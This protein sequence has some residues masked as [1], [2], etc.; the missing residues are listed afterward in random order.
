MKTVRLGKSSL[1]SS[2]LAY[3]CWRV[4]GAPDPEHVTPERRSAGHA[5]ILAA[6]EA[7]YT[8]FDHADV[9]CRGEAETIFGEVLREVSGMRERVLIATKCG[10]RPAGDPD[11]HAPYRYDFSAS[12]IVASCE[13]SLR[14]L[15]VEVIDLYLLHRPDFLCDPAEV[16][17][18]F[19]KLKESGKVREFGV[20]NFRPSQWLMLQ[21]AC[22]LP[23]VV[24]QIQASLLH[25][26]PFLDGTLDQ[27][28]ANQVV[29]M[30]W[31]P[32]AA[33]I[34]GGRI[35]VAMNDPQHARKAKLDDVLGVLSR[36]RGVSRAALA[37]AWLRRHPSR[38]LPIIGATH[39]DHIREAAQG[40][41]LELTRE[42]WYRLMEAAHGQRLP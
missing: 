2:V 37:L 19:A 5:A 41:E 39:P 27:C 30:A 7:G 34:L 4:V 26:E 32:L 13:Q 6:Y 40:A 21:Q 20:S 8:L 28:V 15:G 12:H 9:Y 36:D 35:G 24:N 1:E 25:L 11:A 10:I 16:A 3:G 23:L 14:R 29:P 31:S 38:I 22:R 18:A 42:E 33:G 17:G